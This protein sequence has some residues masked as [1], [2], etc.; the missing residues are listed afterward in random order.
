MD[1]FLNFFIS[2]NEKEQMESAKLLEIR[3]IKEFDHERAALRDR[4]ER[5]IEKLRN[6]NYIL[7]CTMKTEQPDVLALFDRPRKPQHPDAD[8]RTDSGLG[9][10][11]N[12]S[13]QAQ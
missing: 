6:E 13:Y 3:L 7:K 5:E 10:Q 1:D 11:P 12:P 2:Q 4:Y 8:S 9:F